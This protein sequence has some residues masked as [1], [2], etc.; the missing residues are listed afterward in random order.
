MQ[1]TNNMKRGKNHDYN[2]ID[3][4]RNKTNNAQDELSVGAFSATNSCCALWYIQAGQPLC[5]RIRQRVHTH[6]RRPRVAAWL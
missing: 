5:V 4:H 2:D 3:I 1:H 6:A